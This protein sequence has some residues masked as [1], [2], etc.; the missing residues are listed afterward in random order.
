[1]ELADLVEVQLPLL[2][3]AWYHQLT[4]ATVAE[5]FAFQRQCVA[6]LV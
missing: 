4:L 6:L 5:V 3:R 1:M 2:Q